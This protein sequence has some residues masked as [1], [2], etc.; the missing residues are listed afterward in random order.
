MRN[1]IKN[2]K[3]KI[4]LMTLIKNQIEIKFR[5][6]KLTKLK[7][8]FFIYL[9]ETTGSTVL[10]GIRDMFSISDFLYTCVS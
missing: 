8:I 9:V 10:A 7:M 6:V 3:L 1:L 2:S 4:R 5:K